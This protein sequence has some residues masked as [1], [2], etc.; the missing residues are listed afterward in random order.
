MCG[1]R[2]ISGGYVRPYK[3]Y[4]ALL[5]QTGTNDPVATVLENTLGGDVVWTRSSDGVYVG[6]LLN[7]FSETRT[8][9]TFQQGAGP[10]LKP[11]DCTRSGDSTISIFNDE[12]GVDG[13]LLNRSLEVRVYL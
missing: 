6:T 4:T 8:F 7:A 5:T 10:S 1:L 3:V 13:Q 11:F 9:V 12:G 2:V